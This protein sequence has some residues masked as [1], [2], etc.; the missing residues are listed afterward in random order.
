M[1]QWSGNNKLELQKYF[2]R[3]LETARVFFARIKPHF[4]LVTICSLMFG[5]PHISRH[6]RCCWRRH[7]AFVLSSVLRHLFAAF[8][9]TP[10][11]RWRLFWHR[12][13]AHALLCASTVATETASE[14][15]HTKVGPKIWKKDK[16]F[17]GFSASKFIQ[18]LTNRPATHQAGI[19]GRWS[20]W[21]VMVLGRPRKMANIN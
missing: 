4:Q 12:I 21:N 16:I 20:R 17:K 13:S 9:Q 5:F 14:E 2:S 15:F 19:M 8:C 18:L 11:C 1:A 3:N 7:R 10:T 6:F